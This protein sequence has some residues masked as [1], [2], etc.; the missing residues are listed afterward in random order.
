MRLNT[1]LSSPVFLFVLSNDFTFEKKYFI[2]ENFGDSSVREFHIE[3]NTTE[4]VTNG[5]VTLQ[6]SGFWQYA[7]YEQL[8]PTNLD[9]D[10]AFFL[11]LGKVQ[12]IGTPYSDHTFINQTSTNKVYVN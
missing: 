12:V 10:N 11:E 1:T 2:C 8:S 4:D 7:V 6:P 5:I 9:P 3:E